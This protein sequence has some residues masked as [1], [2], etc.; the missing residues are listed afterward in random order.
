MWEINTNPVLLKSR[1]E[2]EKEAPAEIPLKGK[3]AAVIG[4]RLKDLD[5]LDDSSTP[6]TERK[7]TVT[8]FL[9]LWR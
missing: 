7:I 6:V 4:G 3:L 8:E 1:A 5:S 9:K 2:Y